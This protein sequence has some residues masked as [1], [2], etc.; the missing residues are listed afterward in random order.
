[1]KTWSKIPIVGVPVALLDRNFGRSSASGCGISVWNSAS[2]FLPQPYASL[3]LPQRTFPNQHLEPHLPPKLRRLSLWCMALHN[4]HAPRLPEAFQ[5]RHLPLNLMGRFSVLPII[6]AIHR[7]AD[8]SAMALTGCYM[9][10]A[11]GIVGPAPYVLRVK[12]AWT[13]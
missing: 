8:Q 11:S 13:P 7:N 4:G 5:G 6:L 3:N 1:M 12:K 2:S 10:L 9:R